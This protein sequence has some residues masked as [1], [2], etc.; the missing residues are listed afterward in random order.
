M[1]GLFT[2]EF[3]NS[4]AVRWS[5]FALRVNNLRG[6]REYCSLNNDR[7]VNNAVFWS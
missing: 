6:V 3:A 5:N 2:T 7:K 4:L 1:L